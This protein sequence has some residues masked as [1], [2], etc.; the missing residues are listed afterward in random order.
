MV[1][2]YPN[3]LIDPKT[4]KKIMLKSYLSRRKRAEVYFDQ[5]YIKYFIKEELEDMLR[6]HRGKPM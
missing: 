5:T 1:K 2:T 3:A 4:N 6:T